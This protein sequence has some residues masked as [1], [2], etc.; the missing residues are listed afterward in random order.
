[1]LGLN[2]FVGLLSESS[3]LKCSIHLDGDVVTDL[4]N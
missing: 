4:T 3:G 1:M 2:K